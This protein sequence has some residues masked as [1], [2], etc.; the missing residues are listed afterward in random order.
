MYSTQ[1]EGVDVTFFYASTLEEELAWQ[2]FVESTGITVSID[3]SSPL[4]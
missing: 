4:V 2:Q 1:G 3:L